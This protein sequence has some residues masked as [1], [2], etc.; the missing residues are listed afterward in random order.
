MSEIERL[1]RDVSLVDTARR[2]G[3]A[4]S[5]DGDEF[6]A[7]CPF[8]SEDTPSFTIFR[9]KDGVGRFFCFGCGEKGD[10]VDFVMKLKGA[11]TREAIKLLGGDASSR[12]NVAPRRVEVRDPYAG[13]VTIDAPTAPIK[14]GARI[15]LYN[16]KRQ[17]TEREWGSFVPSMVF[18]YRL[19][20]GRLFGYV[21]R[22]ELPDGGKETP[23]VMAVRLP[24]GEKCWCRFPFP[25][26][27]PLYGLDQIDA[28]RQILIVE[29]EK[30]RD[31]LYS[32]TGRNVVSWPGGTQGVKHT[33]WSPLAGRD[34]LIWGDND[35]PGMTT[36]NEIGGILTGMGSRV[37][38]F[39]VGSAAA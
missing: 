3:V 1:R 17:G 23:M 26:P 33:D 6:V 31:Y 27:R 34:C 15:K 28:T 20:D 25:K 8:H 32:A 38:W 30:C 14:A 36:L 39:D 18:P 10:V 9:G 16:P 12:P 2:N 21:L 4:L 35:Q 13:I 29:G 37:R 19:V 5:K 22:H 24:G 7:C 11:S